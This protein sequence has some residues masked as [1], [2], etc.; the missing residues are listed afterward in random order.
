MAVTKTT[1]VKNTALDSGLDAVFNSG[2]FRI[3]TGSPPGAAAAATGTLL[4]DIALP[5]DAFGAAAS[6]SKAKAG[7]W[8]VAAAAT[9]TAGYFRIVTS[10]D[11]NAATENESRIEGT[12]T[13]T[14][15]GGDV[16]LDNTSITSGQTV[17]MNSF[18]LTAS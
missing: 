17:T 3:Y 4:V 11:T 15:G 18:N 7:T 2:K 9:G 5:A 14:A 6:S 8:S 12:V 16:T 13:A 1:A 10:S